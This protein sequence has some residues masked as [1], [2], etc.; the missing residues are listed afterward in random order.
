[1][2]VFTWAYAAIAV[3]QAN[4][5]TVKGV[6]IAGAI[7]AALLGAYGLFAPRQQRATV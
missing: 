7:F 4:V 1:M 6:A 3:N 2:L 5:P